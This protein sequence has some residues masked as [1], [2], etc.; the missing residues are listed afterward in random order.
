MKDITQELNFSEAVRKAEPDWDKHRIKAAAKYLELY[1]DVR[2][3]PYK[4]REKL[5]EFDKNEGFLYG[6]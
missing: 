4:V 6:Q 1:M 5:I 3:K 2:L